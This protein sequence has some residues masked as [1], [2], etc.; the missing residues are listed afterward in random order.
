MTSRSITTPDA[1]APVVPGATRV[2]GTD[3]AVARER[4]GRLRPGLR[5]GAFQTVRRPRMVI[6]CAALLVLGLLLACLSVTT[7]SFH[8][9]LGRVLGTV[10]GGGTTS[11]HFIIVDL[12]M[13]RAVTGL[14]VG[15]ALG[16]SGALVQSMARNPL[17]SPD[18]LG[19]NAG[20]GLV[21][22]MAL[23]GAGGV[24]SGI[25][26]AVGLSAAAMAGGLLTGVLVYALAWRKGMVGSRL[27]L[28]GVALT[29]LLGAISEWMMLRVNIMD[30]QAARTWLYGSL[31]D[32]S[33]P[34]VWALC[35][36]LLVLGAVVAAL[37]RPLQ[38]LSLTDDLAVGLGVRLNAVRALAMVCAV[39]LV[40]LATASSGPI[41]FVAFVAPQAAQRL[42]RRPTPPL[43]ASALTGGCLLVLSDWLSR[44]VLPM[45][46]PVGVITSLIG[47]PF[48]VVLLIR[49]T[50]RTSR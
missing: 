42:V 23:T 37:S 10:A 47:G 29:S 16:L 32:S 18:I 4:L 45:A 27:V 39:L 41:G 43:L 9:S 5:L 44:V 50:R 2:P 31:A 13:P 6:V 49:Q 20:A 12:R 26:G 40:G 48:M 30:V 46:L 35:A 28:I 33:W 8:I 3:P 34:R 38:A 25:T 21:A 17:A 19:I 36:A 24:L 7:G 11:D 15:T 1:S 22:V 14:L